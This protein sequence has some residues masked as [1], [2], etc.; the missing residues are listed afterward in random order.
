VAV[1]DSSR[2]AA[3]IA[4]P[5]KAEAERDA[6]TRQLTVITQIDS[7]RYTWAHA[8][9]EVSRSLPPVHLADVGA[10]DERAAGAAGA[11]K[12]DSAAATA[13]AGGGARRSATR[14]PPRRPG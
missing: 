3:A 7:A 14:P 13:H 10:A 8:L 11:A 5:A 2:Y 4:A 9:D 6:V 1:A 12:P